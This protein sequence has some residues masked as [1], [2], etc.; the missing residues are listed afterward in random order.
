MKKENT[1]EMNYCPDCQKY[2]E[3]DKENPYYCP[4]CERE[5][6]LELTWFDA[7]EVIELLEENEMYENTIKELR[8]ELAEYKQH[9]KDSC[10]DVLKAA[11]TLKE[12][13]NE[14]NERLK[15]RVKTLEIR[16][17]LYKERHKEILEELG[18][19]NK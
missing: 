17:E 8:K 2:F 15:D 4:N 13:E 5:T 18:N 11:N 16:C 6:D 12:L 14:E 3:N 10:K 9:T 19:E 1:I 7:S